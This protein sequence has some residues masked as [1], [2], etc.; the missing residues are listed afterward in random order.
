MIEWNNTTCILE[1]NSREVIVDTIVWNNK[2]IDDDLL[3]FQFHFIS[4]ESTF[5]LSKFS[6][7][8]LVTICKRKENKKKI[9]KCKSFLFEFSFSR[10]S[11]TIGRGFFVFPPK[12][13]IFLLVFLYLML[14][15]FVNPEIIL[16]K[17]FGTHTHTLKVMI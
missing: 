9:K 6:S 2:F 1:M 13:R 11:E 10:D 5:Q 3:S 4:L 8:T 7:L 17:S 15:V 12:L 14:F 16:L